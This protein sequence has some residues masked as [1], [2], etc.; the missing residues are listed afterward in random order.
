MMVPMF[1]RPRTGYCVHGR[2]RPAASPQ[3]TTAPGSHPNSVSHRGLTC[4]GGVYVYPQQNLQFE[5]RVDVPD[6]RFVSLLMMSR[7]IAHYQQFTA[8]PNELPVNFPAVD[9]DKPFTHEHRTPTT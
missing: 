1:A 8:A 3:R 6:P 7:E 2:A 5:V 9:G 4:L